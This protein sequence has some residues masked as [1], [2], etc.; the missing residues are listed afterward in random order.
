MKPAGDSFW[1]EKEQVERFAARDPDKRLTELVAT[2][3]DPASVRVLDLGCAG[4]RNSELLARR[5]FDVFAVDLSRAMVRHTR[6]RVAESL[7]DAE[8]E[9]RVCVAGMD[10]LGTFGDGFFDLVVAL[11]VYHSARSRE[12]FGRALAETARVLRAGGRALVSNFS[13]RTNPHGGGVT[14]VP[15]ES[16]VFDGLHSGRHVLLE[17]DDLDAEMARHGLVPAADTA[18]VV[19]PLEHGRRVTVN[20]FYVRT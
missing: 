15:G 14:P 5:G 6:G 12:E 9:R 4:G 10:D 20:G 16:G 8:A 18:T 1:E 17:A 7:G 3:P 11:G 13:P 19:V 2:F